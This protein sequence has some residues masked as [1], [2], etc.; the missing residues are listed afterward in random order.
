MLLHC[1]NISLAAGEDLLTK[2]TIVILHGDDE[3]E[4]IPT[5]VITE[6]DG[7]T[8][9][10]DVTRVVILICLMSRKSAV[11]AFFLWLKQM[12]MRE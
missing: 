8:H 9:R 5:P 10:H 7:R 11:T 4:N 3:V 2:D 6:S 12:F 1:R